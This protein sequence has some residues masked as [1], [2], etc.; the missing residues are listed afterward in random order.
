MTAE[1]VGAVTTAAATCNAANDYLTDR[2][3]NS[4]GAGAAPHDDSEDT[5]VMSSAAANQKCDRKRP[6]TEPLQWRDSHT[7]IVK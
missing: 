3:S 1:A 4:L 6:P 5:H 7:V 2:S